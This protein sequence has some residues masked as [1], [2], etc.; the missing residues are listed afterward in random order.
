MD[1]RTLSCPR[2][3]QFDCV[4]VRQVKRELDSLM[5]QGGR[6]F[7]VVTGSNHKAARWETTMVVPH[8]DPCVTFIGRLR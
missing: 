3:F 7:A 5:G 2:R 4:V 1:V 6:A 8:R